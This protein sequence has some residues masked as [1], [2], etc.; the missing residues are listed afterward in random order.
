[1]IDWE[2][3]AQKLKCGQKRRVKHC[4]DD[5]S[6]LVN[7]DLKGYSCHCFRCGFHGFIPHGVQSIADIK[8]REDEYRSQDFSKGLVLPSDYTLDIPTSAMT[9]FL[10]SGISAELAREH[11]IGYSESMER[12]VLPVYAGSE[13]VAVQMRATRDGLKPKYLNP[14]GPK[15]SNAVFWAGKP[16][17]RVGV[18]VEDMLSAIKIGQ[19]IYSASILGTNMTDAR[20]SQIARELDHA[21][22][23]LDNDKAGID[24]WRKA[25]TPLSMMGV[26]CTRVRSERDPKTYTRSEIKAHILKAVYNG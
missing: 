4:K 11:L 21:L 17:N 2:S 5:N 10:K 24:G 14:F 25:A 22:I 1:M 9:W 3:Q 12:V 15:V 20:A 13:L 26:Y 8:R 19:Y 18:V 23:W 16:K 7:H 6:M